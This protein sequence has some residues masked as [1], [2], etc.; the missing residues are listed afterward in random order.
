MGSR[1]LEAVDQI[2]NKLPRETQSTDGT[3][4]TSHQDVVDPV[5]TIHD[6]G[7]TLRD[8]QTPDSVQVKTVL[9][10][11]ADTK[12]R[13][14]L[15]FSEMKEDLR[16]SLFPSMKS[17]IR[18]IIQPLL[19]PTNRFPIYSV[20]VCVHWEL[21]SYLKQGFDADVDISDIVT[22]TGEVTRAQALPCGEYMQQTWPRTGA[23]TL[24]AVKYALKRGNSHKYP[25]SFPIGNP[26]PRAGVGSPLLLY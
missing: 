13:Q 4:L 23:D 20:T 16:M 11:F 8:F 21:E 7:E 22:L 2:L 25:Q 14:S 17:Y 1:T 5:N 9:S 19:P 3:S 12:L 10:Q 24:T 15:P 26:V 6:L 18:E